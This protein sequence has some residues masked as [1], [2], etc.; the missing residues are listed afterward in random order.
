MVRNNRLLGNGVG[1]LVTAFASVAR[2][3]IEGNQVDE[4][5]G[6]GIDVAVFCAGFPTCGGEGMVIERN[7]LRRNGFAADL[8]GDGIRVRSLDDHSRPSGI[9]PTWVTLSGNQA[10]RNAD[11]GIDA[12]GVTDGGRN[13]AKLNG[14]PQECVGVDCKVPGAKKLG[15]GTDASAAADAERLMNLLTGLPHH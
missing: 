1:I 11:L 6:T 14:D 9:D 4:N 10:D 8:P 15:K 12:P 5:N 13:R 3:R 7:H 2:A